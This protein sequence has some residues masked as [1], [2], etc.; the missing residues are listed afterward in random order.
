M[1]YVVPNKFILLMSYDKL[2]KNQIVL[3][4]A[5]KRFKI[6]STGNVQ[7]SKAMFK[8]Y[9]RKIGANS[10][11]DCSVIDYDYYVDNRQRTGHVVS[12]IPAVIAM[13]KNSPDSVNRIQAIGSFPKETEVQKW[14][15]LIDLFDNPPDCPPETYSS[16]TIF[17]FCFCVLCVL[18]GVGQVSYPYISAFIRSIL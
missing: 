14:N 15:A 11:L 6:F 1:N 18:F 16:T 8:T 17:M 3:A 7:V 10:A 12:G 5:S 9:C 2:R 13:K 4:K